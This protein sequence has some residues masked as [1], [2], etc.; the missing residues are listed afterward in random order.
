MHSTCHLTFIREDCAF[1]LPS[2]HSSGRT[3]RSSCRLTC[4]VVREGRAFMMPSDILGSQ[5][6][7]CVHVFNPLAALRTSYIRSTVKC[8]R[9][10][11]MTSCWNSNNS[12]G[13][14]PIPGATECSKGPF[15][16]HMN[17]L[18]VCEKGSSRSVTSLARK[19]LSVR[20][21]S[22]YSMPYTQRVAH[23][24]ADL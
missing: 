5:G 7:L 4:L 14:H 20:S 19:G 8:F 22:I 3:V 21:D 11:C 17:S 24:K 2:G 1:I 10:V 15:P 23:T 9:R 13:V 16:G 6:G 18:P 12:Q